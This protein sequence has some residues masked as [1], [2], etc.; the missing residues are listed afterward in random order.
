MPLASAPHRLGEAARPGE[1]RFPWLLLPA[2]ALGVFLAACAAGWVYAGARLGGE[3][4]ARADAL[5]REGWTVELDGRRFEGFPFR[6]KF[7]GAR[8]RLVAPS[9][10]GVDAPD[11]EAEA[12][13][14]DPTHWV[15]AAPRGLVLERGAAGPL[16][17]SG[18]ALSASV[19]GVGRRPWRVALVGEGLDLRPAPGARAPTFAVAA[20]M[21]AYLKPVG[22]DGDGEVLVQLTDATPSPRGLVHRLTGGAPVT[23][24]LEGRLA[25]LAAYAGPDAAAG[26]GAWAA[27]GGAFRVNRVEARGGATRLSATGGALAVGPDGRLAGVVPLRLVQTPSQVA[28]AADPAGEARDEA[29]GLGEQG[30]T[31]LVFGG[32][33]VR[34]GGLRV[35]PSPKVG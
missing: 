7:V 29:A 21:E 3:I 4:D 2:A 10:W 14:F 13:I 34:L 9:G 24:V 16:R 31:R 1:R 19:A 17:V 26:A 28:G 23:A 18:R 8:V 35:G 25:R 33:E 20:R 15:F 22:A 11:A 27:A 12:L 30:D 5:R 32:G 6:L